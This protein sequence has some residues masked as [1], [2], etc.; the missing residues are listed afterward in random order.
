MQD[1]ANEAG[2]SR[3]LVSLVMR[4]SPKVSD[5][6]RALVRQTADRL[7]YRPNAA[8]RSLAQNHSNTIGVILNDLHN[9]FFADAVDGL[10]AEADRH[11]FRLMLMAAYLDP[12]IERAAMASFAEHRMDAVVVLG[13]N[14][15]A[16]DLAHAGGGIPVVSIGRA[17]EGADAVVNDDERGGE[18][19]TQHLIDLGHELIVHI[20]GG[21]GAGASA[22]RRGYISVM[23]A[24][25][26]RPR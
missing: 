20:D 14:D 21:T 5:Q 15:P 13:S 17:I 19:A 24:N 18:L 3:A 9:P 7:G 6:R 16:P 8:A 10:Q 26:S 23:S 11:G 12:D 4:D 25:G 2:V 1:V 22:R